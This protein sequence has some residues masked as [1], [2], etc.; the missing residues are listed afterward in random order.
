MLQNLSII[1]FH[2][3]LSNIWQLVEEKDEFEFKLPKLHKD[4]D[5]VFDLARARRFG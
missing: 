5:L 2:S 4:I 1:D 3:V